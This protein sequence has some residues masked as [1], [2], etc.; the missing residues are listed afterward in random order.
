LKA[1]VNVDLWGPF[2]TRSAIRCTGTPAWRGTV[3]AIGDGTYTTAPVKLNAGGYYTF[4]ESIADTPAYGGFSGVCAETAETTTVHASP[5]LA[6]QVTSQV[7]RPGA[8]IADQVK[9]SGLGTT[10]ARIE[11]TLYGPFATRAAIGC[12]NSPA[13]QTSFTARG[14]NV[15]TSPPIRISKAG[16]YVFR[17][18]LVGS[19]FVEDVLTSCTEE[20]E[21]SLGAPLVITGRGDVTRQV[22]ARAR[23]AALAPTRVKIDSVGIDATASAVAIDTA[24]GVLGVSPDIHHTGWWADGAQPGDRTGAVV[25]AGHVDRANVGPGAFFHLKDANPGDRV[26]VATAG[27]RAFAYR[28]VSVKSYLKSQLPTDVWSR[29]GPARLVLVTCGGPFDHKTRHYRDNIVLTAVPV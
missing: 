16:F 14:D 13:G 20:S 9:V 4:H 15:Y 5:S 27:G 18:H 17:E 12:K 6:T 3:T 8:G 25:I 22:R 19:A 28:V 11:V 1:E 29:S 23:S 7:A 26:Q 10:P 21:V 2:A 24:K